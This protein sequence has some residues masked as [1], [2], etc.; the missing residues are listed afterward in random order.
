MT[1]GLS[2]DAT[3]ELEKVAELCGRI[4]Y[5]RNEADFNTE[6][7]EPLACYID[8]ESA[9]FRSFALSDGAPKPRKVASIGIPE[10]VNDAY[11]TRYHALDPARRLLR[12]R[13][14]GPIFA[15]ATRLGEWSNERATAAVLRRRHEEFVRYRNEFL[16]PNNFFH[17]VGFGFQ[18]LEGRTVLFDFHRSA[19]SPAFSALE[20]ART[21]IVAGFLQAKAHQCRHV[22][23]PTTA[24]MDGRL[25]AREFEVAE[26]VALG[27]SNKEVAT[28]LHISV[29]T[30][31]N[32]MRS[33]FEKLQVTTRTRLAAK[34]HEATVKSFPVTNRVA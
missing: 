14:T 5:S 1:P 13:I 31:E 26:A 15:H 27:L 9:S 10:S 30:V 6:I 28:S 18:D 11:L 23:K 2:M 34:L 24:E 12:R 8:A 17:H 25:S 16:L 19:Q 32:H 21:R 22:H 29:R 7:L 33:I 4:D 3:Q 20:I